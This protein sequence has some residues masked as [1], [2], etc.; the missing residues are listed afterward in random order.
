M[1]PLLRI[2]LIGV[3]IATPAL[4][5]K[6]RSH[7]RSYS[8]SYSSY[9]SPSYSNYSSSRRKSSKRGIISSRSS[10]TGRQILSKIAKKAARR[11]L[12]RS[13]SRARKRV[14][15]PPP[16]SQLQQPQR[17]VNRTQPLPSQVAPPLFSNGIPTQFQGHLFYRRPVF[18]CS[19]TNLRRLNGGKPPVGVDRRPVSLHYWAPPGQKPGFVEVTAEEEGRYRNFFLQWDRQISIP[20]YQLRKLEAQW[21]REEGRRCQRD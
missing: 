20:Q 2:I 13:R 9:S 3:L 10:S 6:R 12:L 15:P 18:S 16:Q 8:S 4:S 21:W 17:E 7:R 5:R 14:P 1:V 19:F 11:A